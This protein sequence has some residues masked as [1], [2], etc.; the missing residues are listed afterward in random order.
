MELLADDMQE[1]IFSFLSIK[2]KIKA[3]EVCSTFKRNISPVSILIFKMNEMIERNQSLEAKL[4]MEM[5]LIADRT[6]IP[7]C[8]A[9]ITRVNPLYRQHR[10]MRETCIVERCREKKLDYIYT[11]ILPTGHMCSEHFY[12]KRKVPYC[13]QCFNIWHSRDT[14]Q[15]WPAAL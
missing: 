11:R 10:Y 9:R 12:T 13:L 1:Y 3:T 5:M 15:S 7:Y 4:S 2:E 8:N 6:Y 14:A